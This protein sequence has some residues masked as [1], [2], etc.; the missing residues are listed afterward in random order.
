[1]IIAAGE[2]VLEIRGC[3]DFLS[4]ATPD[5][6]NIKYIRDYIN[7]ARFLIKEHERRLSSP[8]TLI[9][10]SWL[11]SSIPEYQYLKKQIELIDLGFKQGFH[12]KVIK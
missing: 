8:Y 10:Y 6:H 1:M 5:T 3:I 4:N 7:R 11:Q 9:E 2:L 12:L